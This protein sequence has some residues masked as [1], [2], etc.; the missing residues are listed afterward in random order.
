VQ[1]A[2][3]PEVAVRSMF[4]FT[5]IAAVVLAATALL[6]LFVMSSLA[7]IDGVTPIPIPDGSYISSHVRNADYADSYR[8][9]MQFSNYRHIGDV[10]DNAFAKGSGAIYRTEKEVCFEGVAPGLTYRVSYILEREATPPALTVSTTV[11]Y[12]DTRGK[13]Y[14]FLALP[15]HKML[16]P[17]M[18]D[19]MSKA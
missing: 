14:F 16:V 17:Y 1:N 3:R 11:H 8:V 2:T 19:R 9:E 12:I 10:I 18:L 15:I 6:G 13:I 4:K 5:F 7:R